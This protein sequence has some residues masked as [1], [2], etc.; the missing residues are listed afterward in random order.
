MEIIKGTIPYLVKLTPDDIN[1]L[2]NAC[3]YY[4]DY[5][6]KE[7]R[8]TKIQKRERARRLKQLLVLV[9]LMM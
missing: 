1:T 6:K 7:Y 9:D 4:K 8:L 3:H 5:L 2:H